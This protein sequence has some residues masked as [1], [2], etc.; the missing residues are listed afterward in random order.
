MSRTSHT[1]P[2]L[3]QALAGDKAGKWS[4]WY[5]QAIPVAETRYAVWL[6]HLEQRH[7]EAQG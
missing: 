6:H 4:E 7:K 5:R 2:K 1:T 3:D